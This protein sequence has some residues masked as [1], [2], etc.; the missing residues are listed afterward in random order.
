MKA[1]RRG[2]FAIFAAIAFAYAAIFFLQHFYGASS[3]QDGARTGPRPGRKP[4]LF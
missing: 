3:G 2:L 1:R 4:T